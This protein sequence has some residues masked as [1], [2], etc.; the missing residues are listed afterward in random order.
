MRRFND[1]MKVS[2]RRTVVQYSTITYILKSHARRKLR[3]R[4]TQLVDFG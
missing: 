2:Y 4:I 3:S 1:M